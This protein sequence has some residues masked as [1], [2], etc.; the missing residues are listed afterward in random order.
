[1]TG[2]GQKL[3]SMRAGF[4]FY[5]FFCK[6]KRKVTRYQKSHSVSKP[7][8]VFISNLNATHGN[9]SLLDP[10]LVEAGSRQNKKLQRN[11]KTSHPMDGCLSTKLHEL[12]P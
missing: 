9:V 10:Y 5:I 8:E 3:E 11:H 12:N 2:I 7:R 1:M 4:F 6:I